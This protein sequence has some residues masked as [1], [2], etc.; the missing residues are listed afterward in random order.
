MD[1]DRRHTD[2]SAC[3]CTYQRVRIFCVSLCFVGL[4][5]SAIE[6]ARHA[7]QAIQYVRQHFAALIARVDLG[8]APDHDVTRNHGAD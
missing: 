5:E 6:R 1:D 4:T 2:F 3:S 7:W 8:A